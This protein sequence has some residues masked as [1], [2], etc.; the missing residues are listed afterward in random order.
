[1]KEQLKDEEY[2]RI[3]K[4]LEGRTKDDLQEELD[5]RQDEALE[6]YIF[7]SYKLVKSLDK[8]KFIDLMAS[9][10]KADPKFTKD[11]VKKNKA[12]YEKHYGRYRQVH[13][14]SNF[15]LDRLKSQFLAKSD[16]ASRAIK[17]LKTGMID[18]RT[19]KPI[20]KKRYGYESLES[21]KK[22]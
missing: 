15:K 11:Y 17:R 18:Y 13:I 1:V 3:V 21:F 10:G 19:K 8:N 12:I 2:N 5:K 14:D 4:S 22:I 6:D 9:K 20:P 7:D 16:G